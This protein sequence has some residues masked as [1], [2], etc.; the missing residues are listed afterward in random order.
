MRIEKYN[1]MLDPSYKPILQREFARNISCVGDLHTPKR[2]V[3]VMNDI[4]ALEDCAE[5][6]VYM[7]ALNQKCKPLG[8]FEISHGTV[9]ATPANPREILIRALLCGATGIVMVHNHPSGN[10]TPSEED[11][12]LTRHLKHAAKMVGLE[13]FDHIIIGREGYVSLEEE[14]IQ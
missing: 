1:L 12:D 11:M 2:I 10:P 9:N 14:K 4:F 3:D 5:E 6:H 8:F 13:L 7:I